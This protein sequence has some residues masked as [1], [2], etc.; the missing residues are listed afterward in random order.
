MLRAMGD[1]V[2]VCVTVTLV[3]GFVLSRSAFHHSMNYRRVVMLGRARVL[4]TR[5]K[6]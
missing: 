6:R 3:D 2:D 1:G 5:W 4:A